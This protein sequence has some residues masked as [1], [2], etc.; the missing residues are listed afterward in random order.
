MKNLPSENRFDHIFDVQNSNL[1]V[2]LV[3]AD[4]KSEALL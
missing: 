4:D 1:S 3:F 2:G